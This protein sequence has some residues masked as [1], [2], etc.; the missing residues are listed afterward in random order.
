[1]DVTKTKLWQAKCVRHGGAQLGSKKMAP[2]VLSP[3]LS[4]WA[5]ANTE[6]S[7]EGW[8]LMTSRGIITESLCHWKTQSTVLHSAVENVR[9]PSGAAC[10]QVCPSDP[11]NCGQVTSL[12]TEDR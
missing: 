12:S 2:W 4:G 11:R 3:V 9:F 7:V 6:G 5:P 1:M 10:C 8:H